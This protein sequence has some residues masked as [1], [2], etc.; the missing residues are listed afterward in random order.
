MRETYV[1]KLLIGRALWVTFLTTCLTAIFVLIF[2]FVPGHR[3]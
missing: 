3:L 1:R 2:Y